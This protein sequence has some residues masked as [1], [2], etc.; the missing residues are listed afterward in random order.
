MDLPRNRLQSW[1]PPPQDLGGSD[2]ELVARAKH[3]D[4]SAF[5]LLYRR[6][7]NAVYNFAAHRLGHREDAEDATQ[8]VFLRAAQS[9]GQCRNDD[10]FVGWLFAIARNVVTDKLRTRRARMAPWNDDLEVED[11]AA[12]P[13]ELAI[14]ASQRGELRDAR[15]RCLTD[16]ERELYD[17]LVQDLT[18]AEIAVALGRRINAVRTRYWRLLDKLRACLGLLATGGGH[19]AR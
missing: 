1:M 6:H 13:D 17:L 11:P 18:Y 7:V 15:A 14:R 19:E 4:A 10:A 8:T 5:G 16:A 3:G 9:L 2:A 12:P